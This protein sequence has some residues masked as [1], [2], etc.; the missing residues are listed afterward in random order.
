M[1]PAEATKLRQ[2]YPQ[3][4]WKETHI[5]YVLLTEQWAYKIMK[6]V[7]LAFLDFSTQERRK[8][9]CEEEIRLNR[10]LAPDMYRA[11]VPV[12]QQDDRILLESE[13]GTILDYAVKMKRLD[14]QCL[15]S[16]QLAKQRVTEQHIHQLAEIVA[17]FHAQAMVVEQTNSLADFADTFNELGEQTDWV[18]EH[19][20]KTYANI[21]PQAL[22]LSDE[23]LAK[24]SA[25]MQE[26]QANGLV[27]DVHGD[28]HSHN[29]FLYDAPII[30]DCISFSTELRQIDL[31]NEV[32]FMS[33]DLE[34]QGAPGLSQTFYERYIQQMQQR[35]VNNVANEALFTYFKLYRAN[36][37]VKVSAID[38]QEKEEKPDV[39]KIVP[40]LE[41]MQQ[42]VK[43]LN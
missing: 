17:R 15:M 31:L 27:R 22:A 6:S 5:S 19:L 10:R 43:E 4:D 40:Y 33:M 21:I 13:E 23:F 25:M 29:I 2:S 11:V 28:L 3:A 30:F 7:R 39:S 24:N 12:T 14:E 8:H 9:N 18:R 38:A 16:H 42:Y 26:R 1:K 32:A 41:L 36:V 34:A 37:R 20:E 35:G